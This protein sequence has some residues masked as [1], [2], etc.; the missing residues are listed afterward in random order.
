MQL[1]KVG[2]CTF[3]LSCCPGMRFEGI[4]KTHRAEGPCWVL[5]GRI[6]GRKKKKRQNGN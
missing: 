1:K 3:L 2:T 5:P 4:K 6:F